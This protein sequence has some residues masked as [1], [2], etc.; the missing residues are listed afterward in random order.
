MK[1]EKMEMERVI[2]CIN[3]KIYNQLDD[4]FAEEFPVEV[5]YIS[6][7]HYQAIIF[8][9]FRIWSS[10]DD[11]RGWTVTEEKEPLEDFIVREVNKIITNLKLLNDIN[12]L[13]I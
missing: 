5:E 9:G 4:D 3:E 1:I 7:G 8:L 11:E 10:G 6:N 13:D 2:E 12:L